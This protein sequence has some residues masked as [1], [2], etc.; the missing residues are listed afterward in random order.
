LK[1]G[2][3]FLV[4][5]ETG[6]GAFAG[7]GS[8]SNQVE[9]INVAKECLLAAVKAEPKS[10]QLWVNLANAY[11]LAG[12]HTN[13]KSCLE[14]VNNSYLILHFLFANYLGIVDVDGKVNTNYNNYLGIV[15]I[16]E[17]VNTIY[18]CVAWPLLTFI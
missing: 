17:K 8:H 14:Q 3:L 11:Y 9:G 7:E 6:P 2:F 13:A 18:N 15:D 5:E 4:H 16:D 10:A 12:E 1:A